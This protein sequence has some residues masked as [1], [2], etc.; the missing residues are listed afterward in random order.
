MKLDPITS[1]PDD[2]GRFGNYGGKFVPETLMVALEELE[3]AYLKLKVDEDFQR[4]MVFLLSSYV[5]RPTPLYYA[6]NLTRRLGGA[7]SLPQKRRLGPHRR[8]QD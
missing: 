1:T 3:E 7:K 4:Q 2:R 5:G 6:A 8:P